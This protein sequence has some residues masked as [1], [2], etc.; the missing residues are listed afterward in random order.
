M[1]LTIDP[2]VRRLWQ[3]GLRS[4]EFEPGYAFQGCYGL[5]ATSHEGITRYSAFGV[6]CEVY[7]R[8]TGDGAWKPDTNPMWEPGGEA[9]A[10]T[11]GKAESFRPPSDVLRWAGFSDD[12]MSLF[13]P[14]PLGEPTAS[15]LLLWAESYGHQGLSIHCM[16]G[17]MV[18]FPAIADLLDQASPSVGTEV[19]RG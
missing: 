6:L 11:Q 10:P 18:G 15:R 4:G 14:R 2:G 17:N 1:P 3:E 9:F 16:H 13:D 5:R 19:V 8:A 7:R 12:L